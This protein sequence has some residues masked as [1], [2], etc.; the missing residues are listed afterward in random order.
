MKSNRKIENE[1]FE[2]IEAERLSKKITQTELCRATKSNVSV[3]SDI[4]HGRRP[5]TLSFLT[6]MATFLNLRLVITLEK[7]N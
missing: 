1:L 5:A 7:T 4:K 3:Y 2:A 6:P